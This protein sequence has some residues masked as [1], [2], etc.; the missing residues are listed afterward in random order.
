MSSCVP[1]RSQEDKLSSHGSCPAKPVGFFAERILLILLKYIHA[2]EDKL[3]L[4]R[5]Q[6]GEHEKDPEL[7]H[8]SSYR[9]WKI[10]P[11]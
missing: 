6:E 1:E 2:Q 7:L 9:P 8:R 11:G 3:E 5:E 4:E 10:D